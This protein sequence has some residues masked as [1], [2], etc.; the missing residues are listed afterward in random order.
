[1]IARVNA[2]TK[3]ITFTSGLYPNASGDD[4]VQKLEFI[5]DR[6]TANGIDLGSSDIYIYYTNGRG[7]TYSHPI[8]TKSKTDDGLYID[9]VWNFAREVSEYM[10]A[11]RF[12]ICAKI[13]DGETITN[14]WNSEIAT[15]PMIKSIG[16][17][18]VSG[19]DSTSYD[20]FETLYRDMQALSDEYTSETVYTAEAYAKGTMNGVEVEPGDI[21]YEDN[22]KYYMEQTR[23]IAPTEIPNSD[24]DTIMS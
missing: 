19:P 20:E 24:I 16:H 15:L 1:M 6:Y 10:G 12:S 8:L 18:D 4:S 23:L 13:V 21:G 7:N 17:R 11:T 2:L 3:E 9:F 5:M 22:A 14:E